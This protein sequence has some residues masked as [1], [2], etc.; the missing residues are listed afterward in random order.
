MSILTRDTEATTAESTNRSVRQPLV[1]AFRM[2]LEDAEM[3]RSGSSGQGLARTFLLIDLGAAMGYLLGNRGN[4]DGAGAVAEMVS[5]PASDVEA[6]L[7]TGQQSGGR[8]TLSTLFLLGAVVG[9]GYVLRT[10]MGSMDEV[11]DQATERARTVSDEAAMRMGETAG[12]TETAAQ[13]A[14]DTIAETGEMAGE[15]IQEGSETAADRV[16]EGGEQAADQMQGAGETVEEVEGQMEEK[17]DEMKE[18]SEEGESGDEDEET[19]E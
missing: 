2:A 17:A 10:R 12:R 8:S 1:R 13:Q 5:E 18:G 4:S 6:E 14:A 9:I 15:Q 7:D 16:E 3:G 19:E 11:V